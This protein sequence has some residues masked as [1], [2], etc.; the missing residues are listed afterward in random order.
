ME[1][2][3]LLV[4]HNLQLAMQHAP[5]REPE[6][7]THQPLMLLSQM[8]DSVALQPCSPVKLLSIQCDLLRT[9]GQILSWD[10]S[11]PGSH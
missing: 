5:A 8:A 11:E 6:Q 10:K 1:R 3:V 7:H 9:V 4:Q 2:A